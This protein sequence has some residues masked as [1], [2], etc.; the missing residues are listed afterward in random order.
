MKNGLAAETQST[1]R[2]ADVCVVRTDNGQGTLDTLTQSF[3]SLQKVSQN[4][5]AVVLACWN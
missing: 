5:E 2:V 3:Q 1:R 4:C